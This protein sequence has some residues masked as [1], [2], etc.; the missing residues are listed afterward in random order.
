MFE[1][2][3]RI[4]RIF[5]ILILSCVFGGASQA[6]AGLGI[7]QMF[8]AEELWVKEAVTPVEGV[9]A[10]HELRNMRLYTPE[11]YGPPM[12]P[13]PVH[14][15]VVSS[16]RPDIDSPRGWPAVLLQFL[17]SSFDRKSFVPT[18]GSIHDPL[19]MIPLEDIAKLQEIAFFTNRSKLWKDM[20]YFFR[21]RQS[22]INA[23]YSHSL[24]DTSLELVGLEDLAGLGI[25]PSE[26]STPASKQGK[27]PPNSKKNSE[28]KLA[29]LYAK[30]TSP[31][32]GYKD[33]KEFFE[34]FY[35]G[36]QELH[37]HIPR[38]KQKKNHNRDQESPQLEEKLT[39]KLKRAREA[40]YDRFLRRSVT[41]NFVNSIL[42]TFI[43]SLK[44]PFYANFVER[45]L[46]LYFSIKY[47]SREDILTLLSLAP[48]LVRNPDTLALLLKEGPAREAWL[49]N[50]RTS[51][52]YW[53]WHKA[54]VASSTIT[55]TT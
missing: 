55:S 40:N 28:P 54:V 4:F 30:F 13:L 10:L 18:Q 36:E 50:E 41:E 39:S 22:L 45:A 37:T 14:H 26:T 5:Q 25:A 52:H 32:I 48:N 17:F 53:D 6:W 7:E 27:R 20:E 2:S 49:K 31:K 19:S 43:V 35:R 16:G 9:K 29:D 46:Y 38:P 1:L 34:A 23:L 15:Q 47:D 33:P 12:F 42:A 44:N 3:A 11:N 51:E 8:G 21:V 24:N